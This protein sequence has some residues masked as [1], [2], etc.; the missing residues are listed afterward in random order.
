MKPEHLPW[1]DRIWVILRE[2]ADAALARPETR[3]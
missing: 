1:M 2:A 3:R